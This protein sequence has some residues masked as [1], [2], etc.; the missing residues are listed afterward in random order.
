MTDTLS[1]VLH[2]RAETA[3]LAPLDLEAITRAGSR[4]VRRR[5]RVG[6]AGVVAGV[7]L[8]AGLSVLPRPAAEPDPAPPPTVPATTEGPTWASG[9]VIHTSAGDIEVGLNIAYLVRTALGFVISDGREVVSVVGDD[10]ERVGPLSGFAGSRPPRGAP[11]PPVVFGDTDG[12]LA[13]WP[14]GASYVVLDQGTGQVHRFTGDGFGLIHGLDGRALYVA[15][16]RG[17]VSI[18]VDSGTQQVLTGR[19]GMPYPVTWEDGRAARR[20]QDG[21]IW[22]D[23]TGGYAPR[24]LPPRPIT[25]PDALSTTVLFSPDARHL[26]YDTTVEARVFDLT[27]NREVPLPLADGETRAYEWLD[28][29]T[30]AVLQLPEPGSHYRLL[31]CH[32]ST[33]DCDVAVPDLGD[34]KDGAGNGV[35]FVLPIG[36][37]YLPYPHG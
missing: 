24:P 25:L 22:V 37:P 26:A 31:A 33:T 21:R 35:D 20:A 9:S 28:E 17:V 34:G 6:V 12:S 2:E 19:G 23:G 3:T 7:A 15:D 10:V 27:T 18:D 16:N 29:D 1:R 30:V 32:L 36:E 14:D 13:A 5:R 8:V 11:P 4:A